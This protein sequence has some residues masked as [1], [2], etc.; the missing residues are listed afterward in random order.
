MSDGRLF[1]KC[2]Y[3]PFIYYY[4]IILIVDISFIISMETVLSV[5]INWFHTTS[6]LKAANINGKYVLYSDNSSDRIEHI[7]CGYT[8][9]HIGMDNK[10]QP[11]IS[12][13]HNDTLPRCANNLVSNVKLL[14]RLFDI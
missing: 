2:T 5:S 7:V 13:W 4:I 10:W 12:Y 3:L 8:S 11:I 6:T 9:G 14:L 1:Y